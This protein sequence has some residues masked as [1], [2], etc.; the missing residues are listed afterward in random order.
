MPRTA[1]NIQVVCDA[2][3]PKSDPKWADKAPTFFKGKWV[4]KAFKADKEVNGLKP[5]VEHMWVK[6]LRVQDGKLI[7]TLSNSPHFSSHLK[8]G[9]EI[10]V[11]IQEIE[12][13]SETAD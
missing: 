4:K 7:G 9:Q 2:H 13:L 5:S 1:G 8:F 11:L 6:V 3:A 12:D 10:T